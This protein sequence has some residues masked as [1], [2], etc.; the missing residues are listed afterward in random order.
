MQIIEA[1]NLGAFYNHVNKLIKHRSVI[2]TFIS[3]NG[4][5]VTSNKNK[6][7]SLNKYFA[8]VGATDDGSTPTL[9]QCK[10][11]PLLE[12]VVYHVQS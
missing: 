7:N 8:S 11:R 1:K 2:P 4:L 10:P 5:I 3:S 9:I 6:A 12:T